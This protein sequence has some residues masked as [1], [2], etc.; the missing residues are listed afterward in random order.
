[1][2]CKRCNGRGEYFSCTFDGMY[3]V[4]CEVCKGK[5]Q[6]H[7]DGTPI[8]TNFERISASPEALTIF[9]E[10]I[11]M[12]CYGCNVESIKNCPHKKKSGVRFCDRKECYKWLNEECKE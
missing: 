7:E 5:G 9:I 4:V 8:V 12:P 3:D 2:K 11:M 6:V 10:D 1:M